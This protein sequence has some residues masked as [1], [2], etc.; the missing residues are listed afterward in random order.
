ME[1]WDYEENNKLGLDPKTVS[2]GN[3]IKT[4]WRCRKCGHVW[5][6]VLKHRVRGSGCPCCAG[7]II[8]QGINDLASQN[9]KL[10]AEWHLTKN[11]LKPTEVTVNSNKKVWWQCPTCG[12]EWQAVIASRNNGRGCPSCRQKG[13]SFPELA[14]VF[15]LKKIYSDTKHRYKDLGFEL[16]IF[17]PSLSLG[18]EYDGSYWHKNKLEKDNLK[19]QKCKENN[20]KLIRLR[21]HS[22]FSTKYADIIWCKEDSYDDFLTAMNKLF[23]VLKIQYDFIIDLEKDFEEIIDTKK[24]KELENSL[25]IKYPELVAEW[26]PVKNGNLKPENFSYNSHKKVWWQCPDC[27]YE[28][29]ATIANRARGSDCPRCNILKK[30]TTPPP[31]DSIEV[32]HAYGTTWSEEDIKILK[33]WY[34]FE[35]SQVINRLPHKSINAIRAKAYKLNLKINK[36]KGDY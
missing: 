1:E 9:K 27:E 19:D 13:I 33:E 34:P 14:L 26:H 18:I 32:K 24:L 16:D 30:Y 21:A 10:A 28:W 7:K 6:S 2:T 20:I 8:V 23:E 3:N 25:A 15:Y 11:T 17:I 35:G 29:Q 4:Y 5:A 36:D 22:L 12:H 31:K